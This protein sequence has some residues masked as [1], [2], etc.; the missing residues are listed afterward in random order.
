MPAI[1]I[2]HLSFILAGPDRAADIAA[3]HAKLFD[4]A[5]WPLRIGREPL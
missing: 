4:P 3:V 5:W 1:D 2:R